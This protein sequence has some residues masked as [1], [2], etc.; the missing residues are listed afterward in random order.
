MNDA[1]AVGFVERAGDLNRVTKNL[2]SGQRTLRETLI[3]RFAFDEFHDK[4]VDAVLMSDIV[5][6]ADVRMIEA[7]HRASLSLESLT[8]LGV[9]R[10]MGRQ[11]FDRNGPIKACVFRAVHLAHPARAE[12]CEDFVWAEPGARGKSHACATALYV[13]DWKTQMEVK[14]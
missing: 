2:L 7:R 12:R 9:I 3:R 10:Q 4:V 5:E 8:D 14:A 13:R 6:S 1:R 11:N